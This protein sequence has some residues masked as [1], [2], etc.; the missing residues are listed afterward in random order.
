[1]KSNG[2]GQMN[3]C[4]VGDIWGYVEDDSAATQCKKVYNVVVLF[5]EM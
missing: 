4:C 3:V 1:M 5:A 2:G